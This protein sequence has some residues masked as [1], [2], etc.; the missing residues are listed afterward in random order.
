MYLIA[1]NDEESADGR[2][3]NTNDEERWK[4]CLWCQNRLPGLQPLLFERSIYGIWSA[5]RK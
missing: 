5:T 3:D 1:A 4:D 2:K